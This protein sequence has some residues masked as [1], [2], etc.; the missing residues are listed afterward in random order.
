V[1]PKV[2]ALTTPERGEDRYDVTMSVREIAQH[3]VP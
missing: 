2:D 3:T 1:L